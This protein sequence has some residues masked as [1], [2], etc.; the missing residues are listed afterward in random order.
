MKK[1]YYPIIAITM[2]I[3]S[4]FI[5]PA[6]TYA[7]GS[8][9]SSTVDVNSNVRGVASCNSYMMPS[10]DTDDETVS[11]TVVFDC[12]VALRNQ[13]LANPSAQSAMYCSGYLLWS[14]T[15]AFTMNNALTSSWRFTYDVDY[16]ETPEGVYCTVP[17][18]NSGQNSVIIYFYTYMDNAA[19][20]NT[21][22]IISSATVNLH[23]SA[24]TVAGSA[25]NPAIT[26]SSVNLVSSGASATFTNDPIWATGQAYVDFWTMINAID[27]AVGKDIDSIVAYLLSIST[28]FPQYMNNILTQ[29]AQ[30]HELFVGIYNQITAMKVQDT[31]FYNNI[32]N[33]LQHAYESQAHEAQSEATEIEEQMSQVGESLELVQPSIDGAFDAIDEELDPGAQSDLFFYL[34]GNGNML[35]TILIICFSLALMGYVLYGRI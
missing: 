33:Y 1:L 3:I 18:V 31:V 15:V 25:L 13:R 26:V 24:Y 4:I 11:N 32:L 2:T 10:N 5:M 8:Y 22:S 6:K 7:A 35:V 16:G 29:M 20:A 30:D 17:V 21:A 19:F 23:I 28:L 14:C 9:V 34:H 12:S 27:T